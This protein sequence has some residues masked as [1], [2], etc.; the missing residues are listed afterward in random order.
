MG[1]GWYTALLIKFK[2][3]VLNSEI[4]D[5]KD[6]LS[7]SNWCYSIKDYRTVEKQVSEAS[8]MLDLIFSFMTYAA[9]CLCLFSLVSSMFANIMEQSKEVGILRSMGLTKF[10]INKIYIYEALVIILSSSLLGFA[11]GYVV[12]FVIV[13]QQILFSQFPIELVVPSSVIFAVT[14]GALITSV[15]SVYFPLTLLNKKQIAQNMRDLSL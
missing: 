10:E 2:A 13:Q 12:S 3:S 1:D 8:T 6:I 11:V 7:D 5:V 14:S 9:L 15:A 4:D